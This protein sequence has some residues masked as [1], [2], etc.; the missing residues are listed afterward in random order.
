MTDG[1]DK[2]LLMLGG[3]LAGFTAAILSILEKLLNLQE[4][5]GPGKAKASS[6]VE[7]RPSSPRSPAGRP[8]PT[9]VQRASYLLLYETGVIV[10][11]G[12]LLN[13][14]GLTLSR[15]LQSILFLDMTGTALAA[16]LLGPWW[17]A[18]VALLSNSL[19]NWLL[20]PE[21]GAD[22]VIF[23]WSLVNMTGGLFWGIMARR[24]GISKL[25]TSRS[26]LDFF[27]RLVSLHFRDIRRR[28]DEHSGNI[29][30]SRPR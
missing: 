22:V 9:V 5:L 27:A 2:D 21:V 11:A 7:E 18:I 1:F 3:T 17:G 10:A 19:V 28:G 12:I 4:R 30:P 26:E 14:V 24:S 6:P 15:H 29:G 23:P 20:Y 25:L 13:Y 8:A 16:F